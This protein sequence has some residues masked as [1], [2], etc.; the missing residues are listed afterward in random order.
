MNV[1]LY[2]I[3]A[4]GREIYNNRR[5]Y[6]NMFLSLKYFEWITKQLSPLLVLNY[7]TRRPY[8]WTKQLF[9]RRV[10]MKKRVQ[11]PAAGNAVYLIDQHGRR[12]VSWKAAIKY[13]ASLA[14]L[15]TLRS[16]DGDGNENVKKAIGLIAKTTIL[17]VHHAF[18][19]ISFPS[20]QDYDVK[21][22][23]FTFYRGSTQATTKFPLSF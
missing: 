8:R 18:L 6:V 3:F 16:A 17:H 21:M 15:G 11:L 19:Y 1:S 12:D 2:P 7:E 10:C 20:L 9:F 14:E 23:N 22:P 13:A 4:E 5:V